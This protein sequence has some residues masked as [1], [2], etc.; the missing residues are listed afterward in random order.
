MKA[1]ARHIENLM[2][3]LQS[4]NAYVRYLACGELRHML[5]IPEET[6]TALQALLNDPDADVAGAARRALDVHNP[7]KADPSFPA[8]IKESAPKRPIRMT[9]IGLALLGYAITS[10]S[11][12]LMFAFLIF[13]NFGNLSGF[14]IN[15]IIGLLIFPFSFLVSLLIS[16]P[17]F[18]LLF[19]FLVGLSYFVAP[20]I[21]ITRRNVPKN[22]A[23]VIAVGIV[24]GLIAAFPIFLMATYT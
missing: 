4:P 18:F 5:D 20:I 17:G 16:G 12:I 23:T 24:M 15:W 14:G 9:D 6:R 7:K 3:M 21:A 2:K 11:L 10:I 13:S 8:E 19:E 1:Y 22:W